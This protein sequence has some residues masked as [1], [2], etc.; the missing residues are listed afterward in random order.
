MTA[1]EN[2]FLYTK[3]LTLESTLLNILTVRYSKT[4]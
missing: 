1:Q 2:A 3:M 4:E